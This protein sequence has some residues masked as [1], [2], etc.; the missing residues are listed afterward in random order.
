MKSK[1]KQGD[2]ITI[3]DSQ[4]I[5]LNRKSKAQDLSG[6]YTGQLE[7]KTESRFS[8]KTVTPGDPLTIV[9]AKT[10]AEAFVCKEGESYI[11]RISNMPITLPIPRKEGLEKRMTDWYVFTQLKKE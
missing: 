1:R 9:D 11:A 7:E 6:I 2:A 10:G 5:N 4:T 8:I 3:K